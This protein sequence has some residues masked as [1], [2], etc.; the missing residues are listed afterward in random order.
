MHVHVPAGAIQQPVGWHCP[1]NSNYFSADA[2]AR[3]FTDYGHDR[4][5]Y[6]GW[7][8]AASGRHQEK[9]LAARRAGLQRVIMPKANAKDLRK[10][11]D[12]AR[13]HDVSSWSGASAIIHNAIPD[14][15][16]VYTTGCGVWRYTPTSPAFIHEHIEQRLP[17]FW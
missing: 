15:D 8:S 11:P 1:G 4:R 7:V 3:A 14:L 5:D 10:L 17:G 12:G 6:P 9:V 16:L 2:Q 13:C